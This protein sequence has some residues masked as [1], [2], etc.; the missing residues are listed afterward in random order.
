MVKRYNIIYCDVPWSYQNWTDKKNGA[1]KSHYQGMS[2][3][4]LCGLPI[5]E[6]AADNCALFFW[7]THPKNAEG[8]HIPIFKAWGFRP[9]ST[10]FTWVKTTK[11]GKPYTGIGF[12]TR[13]DSELCLL[14]IK[15]SMKVI[16]KKVKQ[17]IISPRG[18]HSAK[19]NDETRKRILELF[20]DLPRI[21]LFARPPLITG[22]DMLG[23]EI[24][25]KD[26]RDAL[27]GII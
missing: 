4:E 3:D 26:I 23:L 19:P 5:N 22:W 9:V 6:I 14:G 12:Y 10:A 20:G 17:T 11:A 18:K 2:V 27:K 15:G 21:E 24:D 8:C 16:S 1:A 25:G 7:I 13:G